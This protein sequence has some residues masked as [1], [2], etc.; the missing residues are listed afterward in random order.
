MWL[1]LNYQI[2]GRALPIGEGGRSQPK[3][4]SPWMALEF[5]K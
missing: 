1:K 2:G 4:Y 3:E 5:W